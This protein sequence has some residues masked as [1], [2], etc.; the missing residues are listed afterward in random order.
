VFPGLLLRNGAP[1]VTVTNPYLWAAV[2]TVLVTVASRNLSKS[3]AAG[4]AVALLG[5]LLQG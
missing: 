4:I 5:G 3:V 2:V 1:A